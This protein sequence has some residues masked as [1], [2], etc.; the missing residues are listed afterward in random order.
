[1]S[2][3][4]ETLHE[5]INRRGTAL[6]HDLRDGQLVCEDIALYGIVPL[7]L[8]AQS[9]QLAAYFLRRYD[10]L[11]RAFTRAT[12]RVEASP[13]RRNRG[14]EYTCLPPYSYHSALLK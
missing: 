14:N 12:G 9:G 3:V 11:P 5:L 2:L 4:V 7:V 8:S 13:I 6:A 1:M 10:L